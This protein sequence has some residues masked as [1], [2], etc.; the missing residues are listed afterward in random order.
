MRPW[1]PSPPT[2]SLP[3]ATDTTAAPEPEPDYPQ[4]R[5]GQ[6]VR[7]IYGQPQVVRWQDG[8][9]VWVEGR[10]GWFHPTKLFAVD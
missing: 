4:F 3:T 10:G 8:C 9:Q 1:P 2:R 6:R 5:P 7:D